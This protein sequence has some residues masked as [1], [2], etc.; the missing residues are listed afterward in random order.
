MKV[1]FEKTGEDTWR[2]PGQTPLNQVCEELEISLPADKFDTFGGYVIGQLGEIPKD[3][4]KTA[5]ESDGLKIEILE[6]LHHRAEL[7]RVTKLK[8]ETEP[9]S[10]V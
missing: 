1:T 5:L 9:G 8:A 7:C 4:A 6:I 3:G 10:E 2:V